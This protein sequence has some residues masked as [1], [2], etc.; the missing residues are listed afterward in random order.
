MTRISMNIDIG[1]LNRW[2]VWL[3]ATVVVLGI[4]REVYVY[5]FGTETF[6]KD[7]RQIALDTEHCLGSYYSSVL[8]LVAALLMAVTGQS[9]ENRRRRKQWFLLALIFV[10]MSVDESVSFHEVMINPLRPFFTFSSYLHYAWIVPGALFVLI[11]G[12]A[13]IPFVFALE[14]DIRNRIILSGLLYVTGALGMEAIGG[15][16]ISIGGEDHPYYIMAFIIEESLEVMGLTLFATALL[17]NLPQYFG[18]MAADMN[19]SYFQKTGAATTPLAAET[20]HD[21]T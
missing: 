21:K 11:V 13:Y 3:S 18:L 1:R 17:K 7:L 10:F 15:H 20:R 16:F 14:P 9:C 12:L 19:F 8:M 6:L 2:L 4:M 5:N